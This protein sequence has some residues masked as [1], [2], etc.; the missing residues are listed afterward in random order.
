[1]KRE[2]VLVGLTL[3]TLLASAT[4]YG[5]DDCVILLHGLARSADSMTPVARRLEEEGYAV[6]NQGYPSRKHEIAELA[7]RFVPLGI[8][9]CRQQDTDRIHFVTHSLGGILVRQYLARHSLEALGHTVML[10]PPNRGS[11]VVDNWKDVPGYGLLNGLAGRQ[12]GTD[13]HSVPLQLGP[14]RF[15]VGIIAGTRSINLILSQSLPNPDD[16]KVSVENTK[17]DGMSDHLEVPHS[18]PFLMRPTRVHDQ[19]VHFL[20]HGRFDRSTP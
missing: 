20:E 14:V 17:V 4:S 5:A 9:A 18:H 19:I 12:L 1:M 2:G 6:V 16:G 3:I 7:E 8:D 10:G 11:Q 15:P 13:E